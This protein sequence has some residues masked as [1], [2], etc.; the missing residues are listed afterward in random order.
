MDARLLHLHPAGYQ[1]RRASSRAA[2]TGAPHML[3]DAAAWLT[4]LCQDVQTVPL[5]AKRSEQ[6]PQAILGRGR[7][8][9]WTQGF[10]RPP[11]SQQHAAMM[12][13]FA[14]LAPLEHR[15]RTHHLQLT[16]RGT[17]KWVHRA[18]PHSAPCHQPTA[19]SS[20]SQAARSLVQPCCS[21]LEAARLPPHCSALIRRCHRALVTGKLLGELQGGGE[22]TAAKNAAQNQWR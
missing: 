11:P 4:H 3:L 9:S 12:R 20:A 18:K 7:V 2:A 13:A 10:L 8:P 17:C 21:L 15:S 16:G 1:M 5:Q 6:A 19:A 22:E 14:L